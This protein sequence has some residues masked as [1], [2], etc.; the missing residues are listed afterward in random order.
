MKCPECGMNQTTV[1]DSRSR[2]DHQKRVRRC[3]G[4]GNTF[5]TREY[6]APEHK[7]TEKAMPEWCKKHLKKYRV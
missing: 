3:Q 1:T 7:V 2:A 6:Y 5:I 4:C